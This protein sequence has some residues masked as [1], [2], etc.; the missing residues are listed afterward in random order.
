MALLPFLSLPLLGKQ[1]IKRFLPGSLFI[2]LFV[3]GESFVARKR[4]WWWFYKSL[5]P[6]LLG[7]VPMIVGPFF[8]GSL[9]TLKLSYGKFLRYFVLNL[10]TD[11]I[12]TY[13]LVDWFKR[14]GYLSLVRMKKYQLSLLFL[15]K[16]ML[17]YGFQFL[18]DKSRGVRAIDE[19]DTIKVYD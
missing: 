6:K 2:S 7:I 13:V 5:H 4:V 12:F 18:V 14:I 16:T 19:N 8:V 15:F 11:S 1:T 9:W 10:F 3:F 17:L